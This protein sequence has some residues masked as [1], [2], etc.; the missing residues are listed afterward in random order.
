MAVPEALQRAIEANRENAEKSAGVMVAMMQSEDSNIKRRLKV[1][2]DN[3]RRVKKGLE[4]KYKKSMLVMPG[5][6]EE[7]VEE[8][9][10]GNMWFVGDVRARGVEAKC[11]EDAL[12]KRIFR[13]M[14][15]TGQIMLRVASNMG[16]QIIVRYRNGQGE[17]LRGV[18]V[19]VDEFPS[20]LD[21]CEYL[22]KSDDERKRKWEDKYGGVIE[23]MN[24]VAQAMI[25]GEPEAERMGTDNRKKASVMVLKK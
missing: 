15:E 6:L 25:K 4:Q 13:K 3:V 11:F 23:I 10:G 5:L 9:D 19:G 8:F 1:Q 24:G 18:S 22:H 14:D 16:D 20:Y 17:E 12:N 7:K 21:V 2:E